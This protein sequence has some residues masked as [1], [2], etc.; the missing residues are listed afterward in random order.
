M[1]SSLQPLPNS[2]MNSPTSTS[3]APL[4]HKKP[5]QRPT[6]TD[7]GT[8]LELTQATSGGIRADRIGPA[9]NRVSR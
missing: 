2:G 8:L 1:N 7:Y 9:P 6:L 5:Y 4:P 3:T